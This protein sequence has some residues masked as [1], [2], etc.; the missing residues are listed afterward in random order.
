VTARPHTS[1]SPPTNTNVDLVAF[2]LD[3]R[4]HVRVLGQNHDVGERAEASMKRRLDGWKAERRS[5]ASLGDGPPGDPVDALFPNR[6]C[7]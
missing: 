7:L 1:C 4:D 5:C 6:Q 3:L 2:E